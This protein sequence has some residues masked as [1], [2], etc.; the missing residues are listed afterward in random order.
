MFVDSLVVFVIFAERILRPISLSESLDTGPAQLED[1][2][3]EPQRP[4]VGPSH[5]AWARRGQS[6]VSVPRAGWVAPGKS[7][8]PRV[9][10][11]FVLF[12]L[13]LWPWGSHCQFR[14]SGPGTPTQPQPSMP[15]PCVVQPHPDCASQSPPTHKHT[16]SM[17]TCTQV[18]LLKILQ[19]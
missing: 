12:L 7:N 17:R 16:R 13:G 10:T 9:S 3:Q 11:S 19:P 1:R 15:P 6:S 14:P 2:G 8:G 5:P 18:G 4:A